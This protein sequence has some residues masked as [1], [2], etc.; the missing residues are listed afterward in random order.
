MQRC[1][2]SR[3]ELLSASRVSFAS[4]RCLQILDSHNVQCF[5]RG[6]QIILAHDREN[7]PAH[8]DELRMRRQIT[9][10]TR[11]L[12][13]EGAESVAQFLPNHFRVHGFF[14]C[15]VYFLPRRLVFPFARSTSNSVTKSSIFMAALW[16]NATR[17]SNAFV[18]PLST[19]PPRFVSPSRRTGGLQRRRPRGK[20]RAV[21]GGWPRR[22]PGSEA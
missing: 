15:M 3:P 1:S 14:G 2:I 11:Q 21:R 13:R 22:V 9:F 16:P 12:H 18:N 4:S 17:D 10:P 7:V 8:H 20:A 5:H 19:H 6:H